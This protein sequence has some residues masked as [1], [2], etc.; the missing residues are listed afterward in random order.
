MAGRK[1]ERS[2]P[3]SGQLPPLTPHPERIRIGDNDSGTA[4][5]TESSRDTTVPKYARMVRKEARLRPDQADALTALRRR[6]SAARS[7]RDEPITDNTLL[8][9]ATDVL[10]AYG[11]DL[12]GDTEDELR[13]SLRTAMHRT[14]GRG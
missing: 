2:R 3:S 11:D 10:L 14:P 4:G 1:I 13:A 9:L 12:I 8:R 5:V 6:V 7:K